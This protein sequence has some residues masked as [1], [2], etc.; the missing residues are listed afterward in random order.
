MTT[1]NVAIFLFDDVEVLDFAGPYEVF[2]TAARVLQ[3]VAPQEAPALNVFNV[4]AHQTDVRARG[5]LQVR[6]H[7]HFN[8]HPDIDVLIIPGGVVTAELQKEDVIEWIQKQ[9]HKARLIASV[10]TGAFLL[11]RAGLL[12]GLMATT[13]WEDINDLRCMFPAVNVQEN[14]RWIDNGYLVTSAGISAG[15][16]MSLHLVET[17]C[18]RDTAL[19]TARQMEYVWND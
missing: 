17:L 19:K 10:C 14:Q 18:G 12:D 5:N 11:A 15:I 4:A 16:D 7:Y 9:S 3:R 13:H 8:D 2:C 6:A 1:Q